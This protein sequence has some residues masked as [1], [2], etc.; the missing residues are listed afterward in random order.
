MRIDWSPKI[1]TTAP[2]REGRA[3]EG[4]SSFADAVAGEKQT[5]PASTPAAPAAIDG[6]F[7]LQEVAEELTGR[8]R[9][10]ARANALLDRLEDLRLALLT[11]KMPRSQLEQLRQMAKEH[12][13]T[14]D[15]PKLAGIL[16]EIELRVAVELAK[17]DMLA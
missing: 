9:A 16:A 6:L 5:A 7:V 2:R 13:P 11:G 10:A 4:G 1:Q 8:R 14:A 15:D 12:G 3:A 17:L